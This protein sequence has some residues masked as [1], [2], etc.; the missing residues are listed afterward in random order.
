MMFDQENA[1]K[2]NFFFSGTTESGFSN[3][4]CVSEIKKAAVDI[5]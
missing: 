3:A 2:L 4:N 5:Y 1:E